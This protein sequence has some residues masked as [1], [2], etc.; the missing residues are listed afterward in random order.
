M[1]G[2]A[3]TCFA[4]EALRWYEGLD[5]DVQDDWKKL[6][7]AMLERF[8]PV[9]EQ[10]PQPASGPSL[11]SIPGNLIPTA[12]AAP[13]AAPPAAL[14]ASPPAGP[15]ES[16]ST[17]RPRAIYASPPGAV[18]AAPP[19]RRIPAPA[20][21]FNTLMIGS[22]PTRRGRVSTTADSSPNRGWISNSPL[23]GDY[24]IIPHPSQD[25]TVESSPVPSGR[26]YALNASLPP[27]LGQTNP[28]GIPSIRSLAGPK[29]TTTRTP[30]PQIGPAFMKLKIFHS[31]SDELI[32]IRVPPTVTYAQLIA[33]VS[34]RLGGEVL[35]LRYQEGYD[36][37]KVWRGLKD[38]ADLTE[39]LGTG[40]KLVLYAN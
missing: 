4:G 10:P 34:E 19:P 38:D 7:T 2:Y 36:G 30:P 1:A 39:W 26:S 21:A 5:E 33:K 32:A 3:S 18:P 8:P 27:R 35:A 15:L 14:P 6:R 29:A 23:D 22:G 12:P 20:A 11:A 17:I 37:K 28:R 25:Q 40:N 9:S 16:P 24:E 31:Q 13:P